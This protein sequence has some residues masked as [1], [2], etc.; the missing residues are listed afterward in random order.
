MG[1]LCSTWA[2]DL[3]TRYNP[4]RL[5]KRRSWKKGVVYQKNRK[6]ATMCERSWAFRPTP[7]AN[8]TGPRQPE[9]GRESH[10][11]THIAEHAINPCMKSKIRRTANIDPH[12]PKGRP[13]GAQKGTKR[14]DRGPRAP[15]RAPRKKKRSAAPS[16]RHPKKLL[17]FDYRLGFLI[18]TACQLVASTCEFK[19]FPGP[20]HVDF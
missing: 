13:K 14:T 4:W 17:N 15:K 5:E 12:A 10:E 20:R 19:R 8:G 7:W 11:S 9:R 2:P 16:P 6:R 18:R 3:S 1:S